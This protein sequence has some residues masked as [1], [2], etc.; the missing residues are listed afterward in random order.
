MEDPFG[1]TKTVC[2]HCKQDLV[3]P[4][5]ISA[6]SA[7]Y[8]CPACS[9]AVRPKGDVTLRMTHAAIPPKPEDSVAQNTPGQLPGT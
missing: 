3:L 9:L 1:N 5:N 2:P 8:T 4:G 6:E 7:C